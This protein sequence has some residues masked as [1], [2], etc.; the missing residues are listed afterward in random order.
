MCDNLIRS[1]CS[2]VK[3]IPEAPSPPSVTLYDLYSFL[4]SFIYNFSYSQAYFLVNPA[5]NISCIILFH[6]YFSIAGANAGCFRLPFFQFYNIIAS[7]LTP[8]FNRI[9][10]SYTY[11]TFSTRGR[12][13][14]HTI[15]IIF[16]H[17]I[18]LLVL[19]I[20]VERLDAHFCL[21]VMTRNAPNH[22]QSL[23]LLVLF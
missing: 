8:A 16:R 20:T 19:T 1:I 14:I 2:G 13:F 7:I 21:S 15:L 4:Y 3:L 22:S 10:S 5:C 9:L 23:S 17:I 6:P 12:V 11:I 18:T